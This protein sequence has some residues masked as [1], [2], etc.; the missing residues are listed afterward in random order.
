[1]T[2]GIILA[3]GSSQR[4]GRDKCFA[5]LGGRPIWKWSFDTF[6][7]HPLLDHVGI[8]TRKERID[9]VR[10]AASEARFV[11][12]GGGTRPESV[13]AGLQQVRNED[14][15]V[16]IHDGARPF[17]DGRIIEDIVVAIR[18]HGAAYPAIPCVDTVRFDGK[19]LDRNRLLCAQTPQGA[20]RE[21][22][23]TSYAQIEDEWPDDIAAVAASG[24]EFTAVRG[25]FENFKIT[26]PNDLLR[27]Q[28]MLGIEEYRTG[29]GYDV[30]RFST[31]P[32]RKCILGGV[33]F[34]GPGL[35]GHSDADAL[36]HAIVD[37][38]FGAAGLPDIGVHFPNTEE[39]WRNA[40][41]VE[42]LNY[43]RDLL[44]ASG[45]RI[46]NIDSSVLAETPKI[47]NQSEAIRNLIAAVLNI[48]V[49]RVGVK[50]TTNEGLGA[51]GRGEG[52]AAMAIA[53]LAKRVGG[54]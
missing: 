5:D 39:K 22:L 31:D 53:T 23:Q 3:A 33:E 49:T 54:R 1:M 35:E 6:L 29:T 43:A 17:V 10:A 4:F 2:V 25:S 13:R 40:R 36:L 15:I 45:Y 37:A 19:L 7:S 14:D 28:S 48:E 46:V 30:H 20:K 41:S 21:L 47:M 38:L 24:F 9:E 8:V 32:S 26:H 18:E 27:A 16:L 50:A 11:V 51:I 34:P 44:T 12:G 42:F 52:I